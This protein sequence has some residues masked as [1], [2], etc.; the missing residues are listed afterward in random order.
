MQNAKVCFSQLQLTAGKLRAV[1]S[2][3][4]MFITQHNIMRNSFFNCIMR[5]IFLY[6]F[7]QVHLTFSQMTDSLFY[8]RTDI[9]RVGADTGGWGRVNFNR[10]K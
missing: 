8:F 3:F 9:Y 6:Y 7:R 10:Q 2:P 5:R 4:R 1:R